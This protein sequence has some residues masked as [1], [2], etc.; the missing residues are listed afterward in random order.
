MDLPKCLQIG[1]DVATDP[2]LLSLPLQYQ[3]YMENI[4]LSYGMIKDRWVVM[5]WCGERVLDLVRQ[6][7]IIYNFFK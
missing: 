7:Q 6:E 5:G 3:P 2:S 4:M 1:D